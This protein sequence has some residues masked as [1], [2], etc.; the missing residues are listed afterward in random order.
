MEF[1]PV[2]CL[3]RMLSFLSI[4]DGVA[5]CSTNHYFRSLLEWIKIREWVDI[6]KINNWPYFDIFT[7]IAIKHQKIPPKIPRYVEFLMIR[8]NCWQDHDLQVLRYLS[9]LKSLSLMCQYCITFLPENLQCLEINQPYDSNIHTTIK[10]HLPDGL[11]HLKCH[12]LTFANYNG[13]WPQLQS[14]TLTVYEDMPI[15]R[16]VLDR[17]AAVASLEMAFMNVD[18]SGNRHRIQNLSAN[19]TS[20]KCRGVLKNVEATFWNRFP[21]LRTLICEGAQIMPCDLQHLEI[22]NN[23]RPVGL[24]FSIYDKWYHQL[25]HLKLDS[26]HGDLDLNLM[27]NL[28]FLSI[29]HL[30]ASRI[31]GMYQSQLQTLCVYNGTHQDG[32]FELPETLTK[33]KI[34]DFACNY[35]LQTRL[36][37]GL[38]HLS[39]N[40]AVGTIFPE[41]ETLHYDNPNAVTTLPKSLVKLC[42][43]RK[44]LPDLATMRNN[45]PKLKE[46]HLLFDSNQNTSKLRL[47]DCIPRSVRKIRVHR[48]LKLT[49]NNVQDMPENITIC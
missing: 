19:L 5:M 35:K 33:F 11:T 42:L 44:L 25:C 49:P 32:K 29:L 45:L 30:H 1:L 18:D 47:M 26:V 34:K 24:T 17:L 39:T 6:G 2:D 12:W 27:P 4:D 46:L 23:D 9:C 7:K 28:T 3:L 38:K 31:T 13:Y 43:Q 22:S 14:L 41:L 40:L 8:D 20:L 16:V 10:C 37:A 15:N 36:T 48:N 21:K